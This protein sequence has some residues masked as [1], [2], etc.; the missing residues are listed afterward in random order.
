M[1]LVQ[2]TQ[3]PAVLVAIDIAKLRH[4]V[5]IEAPGWKNRKRMILPNTAA[6]FR[7]F[8]DFLHGLKH[9]V[10]VVFEA[11]GNY[12]RR[13][14]QHPYNLLHSE[15]LL[16]HLPIL[17]R[18]RLGSGRRLTFNLDQKYR[19]RSYSSSIR[20]TFYAGKVRKLDQR[21]P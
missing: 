18:I 11:T 9:P 14:L 2:P 21:F 13:L 15:A 12:H 5:L 17:R 7:L 3:P 19:G 10:R 16:L 1:S 8:A 4:D 6:E 20:D